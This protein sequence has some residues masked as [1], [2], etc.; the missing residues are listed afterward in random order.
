[1]IE[2]TLSDIMNE[3]LPYLLRVDFRYLWRLLL[4]LSSCTSTTG[5][6]T[7]GGDLRGT[8]DG[9]GED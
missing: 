3:T 8:I 4:L 2:A 1:M 6:S 5:A 9:N 7:S